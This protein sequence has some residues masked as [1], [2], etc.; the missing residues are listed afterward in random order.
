MSAIFIEKPHSDSKQET[1]PH[2]SLSQSERQYDVRGF[3]GYELVD[4][5][6]KSYTI[7]ESSAM[8][9]HLWFGAGDQRSH[10]GK[11]DVRRLVQMMQHWLD[12]GD[13]PK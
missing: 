2:A 8:T 3:V 1:A 4:G 7:Q 9:P 13:L 10:L 11:K 12:T 5:Y 6:Q